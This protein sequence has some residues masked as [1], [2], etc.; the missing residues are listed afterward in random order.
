MTALRLMVRCS[1]RDPMQF[2]LH[3]RRIGGGHPVSGARFF[4]VVNPARRKM[5][6]YGFYD[7]REGSRGRG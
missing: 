5:E 7:I 2:A 3:S 6:F 1:G 4:G